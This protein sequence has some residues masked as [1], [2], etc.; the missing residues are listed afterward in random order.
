MWEFVPI[1]LM[2]QTEKIQFIFDR[3][4]ESVLVKEEEVPA[5]ATTDDKSSWD[6]DQ[7]DDTG[8]AKKR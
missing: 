5:Q 2:L 4:G 3:C 1:L 7:E 6:E 8:T